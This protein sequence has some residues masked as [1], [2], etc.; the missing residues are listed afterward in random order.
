MMKKS[1]YDAEEDDNDDND[2][3]QRETFLPQHAAVG[4]SNAF[5]SFFANDNNYDDEDDSN[6]PVDDHSTVCH[7]IVSGGP[8]EPN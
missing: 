5:L 8:V 6:L 3:E 2:E 4:N 1:H 7:T